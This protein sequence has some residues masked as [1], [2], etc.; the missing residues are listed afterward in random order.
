MIAA[1]LS[2]ATW[3]QAGFALAVVTVALTIRRQLRDGAAR[4]AIVLAAMHRF[5]GCVI[6]AMATGHIVAV[7][8]KMGLGTLPD[9]TSPLALP[10]GVAMAV[11]AWWLAIAA[12]RFGAGTPTSLVLN[13][14]L[15]V[16]FLA[17]GTS[18]PL[19]IPAV[20][21]LVYQRHARRAVG[22]AAAALA[23][24]GFVAMFVASFFTTFG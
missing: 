21:N 16:L 19:A 3:M 10:L 1:L 22:V 13:G 6:G 8:L 4:R 12:P 20:L 15:A 11:P 7:A 5:Y 14:V 23:G 2:P 24:A 9:T 17:L 18:A